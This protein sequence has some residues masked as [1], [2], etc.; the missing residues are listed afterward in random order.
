[1]RRK[2]AL[3]V[4]IGLGLTCTGCEPQ[5]GVKVTGPGAS[6]AAI[7]QA[8]LPFKVDNW[9]GRLKNAPDGEPSKRKRAA[10]SVALHANDPEMTGDMR[11]QLID[12]LNK[13][14]EVEPMSEATP[15][16]Q[17]EII[18]AGKD[19]LAALEGKSAAGMN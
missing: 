9:I 19:A 2:L 18:A 1:M 15:E 10:I 4:A 5:V 11:A 3:C 8:K 13:M 12:A 6:P 14:I 16:M 7:A 17:Q